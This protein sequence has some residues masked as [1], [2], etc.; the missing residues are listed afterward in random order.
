MYDYCRIYRELIDEYNKIMGN[1][2]LSKEIEEEERKKG[3]KKGKQ[4]GKQERIED[5]I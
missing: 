3:R 4:K 1:L 5:R 2:A